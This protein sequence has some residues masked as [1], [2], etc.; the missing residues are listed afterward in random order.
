MAYVSTPDGHWTWY[1]GLQR[2]EQWRVVEC[3][4][5]GIQE[6]ETFA[7]RGREQIVQNEPE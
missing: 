4:G 6:L 2:N 3:V 7:R 1:V 5:I